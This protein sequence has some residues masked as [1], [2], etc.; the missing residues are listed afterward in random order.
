[1]NFEHYLDHNRPNPQRAAMLT[2][3]AAV[4]ITGTT[5]M[6][7]AG[8]V[9]GKMSIARVD[10]PSTEYILLALTAE[11]P[12]PP[13]P[14]P[15]PPLGSKV[16][17]DKP[18]THD[19]VPE[20]PEP[21]EEVQ[22]EKVPTK[23]PEHKSA[24]VPQGIPNGVLGGQVGGVVG[25]IP[26]G[27]VG[28]GHPPISTKPPTTTTTTT[29]KPLAAVMAR[30]VYSPDP[31]KALLQQTKAARFD[32]RDGKSTVSFCIDSTG[33][34][35]KVKTKVPFPND[36]QVDDILRRT[37]KTWRFKP[38]EVGSKKLETCTE[39]TFSLKFR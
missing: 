31:D 34:V 4:A 33:K 32:K 10:P 18:D 30:A 20:E 38:L 37:L 35:V 28:I 7:A 39:R 17:E 15:P 14:P 3:A 26:I 8:W 21:L 2:F 13:P 27:T 29:V 9:A 25:G 36:P 6:I 16:E 24:G 11:Q 19:E 1:M 12:P 23:I 5:M 22:P